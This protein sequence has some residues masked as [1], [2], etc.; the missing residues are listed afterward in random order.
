MK[1]EGEGTIRLQ[2]TTRTGSIS[3][4]EVTA[5]HC[6]DARHDLLSLA[7][8]FDTG[9]IASFGD[10]SGML[11]APDGQMIELEYDTKM[12]LWLLAYKDPIAIAGA[13]IKGMSV[14]AEWHL[15][16]AH[17]NFK[18]IARGSHHGRGMPILLES[19]FDPCHT[20][21]HCKARHTGP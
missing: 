6:P 13:A 12:K 16:A 8:I 10:K 11:R 18:A 2:V 9:W 14:A 19:D 1:A 21:M 17:L 3:Y 7:G 5:L 20:C 15:R 4:I